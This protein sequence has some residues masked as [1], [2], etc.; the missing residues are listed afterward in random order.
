MK[1]CEMCLEILTALR[2]AYLEACKDE[3][4][5]QHMVIRHTRACDTRFALLDHSIKIA[6]G[7]QDARVGRNDVR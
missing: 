1:R 5:Y 6:E 7:G 4:D 3:C 2:L